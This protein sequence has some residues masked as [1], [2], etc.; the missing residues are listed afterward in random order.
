MKKL[1]YFFV[2]CGKV[3]FIW[4]IMLLVSVSLNSVVTKGKVNY[5]NRCYQS[6]D[7]NFVRAYQYSGTA[8]NY[9]KL[10][11]NTYYLEYETTLEESENITFLVSL[12]KLFYD[13]SINCNIHVILKG[14]GYQVLST[15]VDYQ[16]TYTKS[17]I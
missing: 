11:C 3:I 4:M 12:S 16:V 9:G 8:L 14:E 17:I 13:N 6:F 2:N 5:G 1:Y 7:D 15:I 10:E